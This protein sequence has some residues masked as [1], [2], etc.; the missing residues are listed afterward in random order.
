M[1]TL[2]MEATLL[3]KYMTEVAYRI[4]DFSY[5]KPEIQYSLLV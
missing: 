5:D 1:L 3:V 4:S 2:Q